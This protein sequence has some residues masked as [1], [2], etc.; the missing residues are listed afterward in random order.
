MFDFFY[1]GI[2]DKSEFEPISTH[3]LLLSLNANL[4]NITIN[5]VAVLEALATLRHIEKDRSWEKKIHQY[6]APLELKINEIK[7]IDI[8][9]LKQ[10]HKK[11]QKDICLAFEHTTK[12][13]EGLKCSTESDFQT[14]F[15]KMNARLISL[16]KLLTPKKKEYFFQKFFHGLNKNRPE[17]LSSKATL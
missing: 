13:I 14:F 11:F 12:L 17:I 3:E 7:A 4:H 9:E 8:L 10:E 16:E 5:Q 1:G 15:K 2:M 6:Y